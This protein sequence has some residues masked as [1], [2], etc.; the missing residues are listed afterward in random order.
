MIGE[1]NQENLYLLLPSKVCWLASMLVENKGMSTIDSIK[2]IYTSN[3]YK[4]LKVESTKIWHLGPVALY[5]EL[6]AELQ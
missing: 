6:E 5:Q 4:R 2:A 3:L 1:I